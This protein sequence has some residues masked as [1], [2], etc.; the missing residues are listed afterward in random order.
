[1]FKLLK[2]LC[3]TFNEITLGSPTF[4]TFW[5]RNFP[6][7]AHTRFG[8]NFKFTGAFNSTSRF[9]KDLGFCSHRC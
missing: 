3:E 5:I 1:M 4:Q 6:P 8:F 9:K 7:L 2:A